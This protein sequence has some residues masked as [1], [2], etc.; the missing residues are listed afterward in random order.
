MNNTNCPYEALYKSLENRLTLI[1][2]GKEFN[3]YE[4]MMR[5]SGTVSSNLP[6]A[7][8]EVDHAIVAVVNYVNNR[9]TVKK[10][11][12]KEKTIKRF[13]LRTSFSA[14]L[15]AVAACALIV[16]CCIYAIAGTSDNSIPVADASIGQEYIIERLNADT[17]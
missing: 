16:S 11:P 4:Y 8:A 15:S 2:S 7:R 14:L 17:K 12:I 13:P 10:A 6:V 1:D 9:L 5:K 3:T